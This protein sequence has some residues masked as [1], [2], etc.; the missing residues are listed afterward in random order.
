VLEYEVQKERERT[1]GSLKERE[2]TE[3]G[4]EGINRRM[5]GRREGTKEKE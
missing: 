4:W 5:K 3:K 1:R 2:K